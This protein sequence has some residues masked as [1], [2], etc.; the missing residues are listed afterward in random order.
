MSIKVIGAGYGRTGTYSLK[1]ALEVLGYQNC[2]HFTELVMNPSG[3]K[4]WKSAL[5]GK[6]VNWDRLFDGYQA[7][8]D[9]PGSLHYR[10][11]A[12]YYPD[13]KVILT[14]RDPEA[15]YDSVQRCIYQFKPDLS[16]TLQFA[17]TLPFRRR[18]RVYFE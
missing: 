13:A 3:V 11:L 2:Y 9:F 16:L 14:V 10:E 4:F 5:R 12:D 7:V 1:T 17:Y 6:R 18:S 8:V 15:W